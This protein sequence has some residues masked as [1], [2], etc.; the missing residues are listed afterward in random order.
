MRQSADVC[1]SNEHPYHWATPA[2]LP[3]LYLLQLFILPLNLTSQF[4]WIALRSGS[5]TRFTCRDVESP[6]LGDSHINLTVTMSIRTLAWLNNY[7]LRDTSQSTSQTTRCLHNTTFQQLFLTI[8]PHFQTDKI[9]LIYPAFFFHYPV[10]CSVLFN[11]FN[12]NTK[13]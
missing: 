7:T 9:S 3:C 2:G 8:F 13:I 4:L 12:K 10:I 11:E 1:F 5:N 6:G